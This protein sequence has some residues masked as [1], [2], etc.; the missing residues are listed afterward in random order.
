M[1]RQQAAVLMQIL[2]IVQAVAWT[3]VIDEM[4]R[5]GW[6]PHEIVDAWKAGEKLAGNS[7]TAPALSDFE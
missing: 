7:G 1:N 2:D 6:Q 5:K 3:D 4:R